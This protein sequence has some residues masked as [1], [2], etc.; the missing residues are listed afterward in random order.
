[1][2]SSPQPPIPDP[3]D[4]VEEEGDEPEPGETLDEAESEIGINDWIDPD[5]GEPAEGQSPPH[6][7]E[8]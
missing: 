6:I 8:D 2:T 1:M 3:T 5:T 4:I 7:E